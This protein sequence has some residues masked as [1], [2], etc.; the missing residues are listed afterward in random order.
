MAPRRITV[1]FSEKGGVG[2][3][4]LAAG[5]IAV[6][7]EEGILV[8]GGDLDPR[9]TL[10][11]ELGVEVAEDTLTV[12]D[13]MFIPPDT[14]PVDPVEAVHDV[15]HPAGE[16]WPGNVFVLPAE[17]AL[18]NRESDMHAV[19]TRLARAIQGLPEDAEVVLDVPPRA[20]GKL[21]TAAMMA[22]TDILF[23]ATLTTDGYIGAQQARRSLRM[24]RQSVNS[25]VRYLGIVRSDVPVGRYRRHINGLIEERLFSDFPGEIIE[26]Q[27]HH[28]AVR[29]DCRYTAVPITRAPGAQA[30][31]LTGEYQA[32]RMHIRDGKGLSV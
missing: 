3:S 20:G 2:K 23:P 21:V 1:I 4:S 24:I 6:A 13:L 12:N 22:A 18:A 25:E 30:P 31:I 29:E 19:E 5:L 14:D 26:T 15:L 11:D 28:Y 10:T 16:H 17:R 32:L 27:I 8:V 9:A 7:A